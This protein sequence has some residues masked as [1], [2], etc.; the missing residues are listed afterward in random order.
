MEIRQLKA[1]QTVATLLSFTQAAEQL[2]YAQSSISAQIQTLEE[3]LEVKLFDRMGRRIMLTD[4]GQRLLNYSGKILDLE[5]ETRAEVT[6]SKEPE[7]SLTIRIPETFGIHY[8]PSI[9]M[10]F[11]DR[12]PKIRLH[13]ITCEHE[14]LQKDLRKGITDLAFL[15]SESIQAGDLISEA[16]G[17]VQ[18]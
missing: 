11:Q 7:G 6:E 15:L 13:F 14:G 16:L 4:A 12:F 10:R 8:L 18:F 17:F 1:F 9:I 5:E 3:E 2:N